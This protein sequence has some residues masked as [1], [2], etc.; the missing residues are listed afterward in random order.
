M[1]RIDWDEYKEHKKTSVRNDNFEI[2][3]EFMKA[4]YNANDPIEI[5]DSLAADDIAIM[6]LEKRS[7][8][9]AEALE[10]FLNKF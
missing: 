6:M 2:L 3:L 10:N 9:D 5:Y 1:I 8:N 7:I 4:Y